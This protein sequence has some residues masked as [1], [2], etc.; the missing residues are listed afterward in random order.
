[1]KINSDV[2][3]DF[4]KTNSLI[5]SIIVLVSVS[6]VLPSGIQAGGPVPSPC[7]RTAT[8][9][10]VESTVHDSYT[11]YLKKATKRLKKQFGNNRLETFK[12]AW[13]KV[14]ESINFTVNPE[15]IERHE[16]DSDSSSGEACRAQLS[17]SIRD[18]TV[19]FPIEYTIKD[20]QVRLSKNLFQ[21][22]D[23][24]F[25]GLSNLDLSPDTTSG[26]SSESETGSMN[27]S[28]TDAITFSNFR[29][30]S[31][32]PHRIRFKVD[33]SINKNRVKEEN[34][35]LNVTALSGGERLWDGFDSEGT[36]LRSNQG[37]AELTLT[38]HTLNP[39]WDG[40]EPPRKTSTD[41][42]QLRAYLSDNHKVKK[43]Y[44][45]KKNWVLNQLHKPSDTIPD[46]PS[47]NEIT[48]NSVSQVD[49]TSYRVNYDYVYRSDHGPAVHLGVHA[50]SDDGIHSSCCTFITEIKRGKHS[51][52]TKFS[53]RVSNIEDH[54][55]T[56]KLRLSFQIGMMGDDFFSKTIDHRINWAKGLKTVDKTTTKVLDN[57]TLRKL[58]R[59]ISSHD[60]LEDVPENYVD[61]Y[62]EKA[63]ETNNHAAYDKLLRVY[64][65]RNRYE[66]ATKRPLYNQ[67]LR[68]LL[69]AKESLPIGQ[70]AVWFRTTFAKLFEKNNHLQ[71]IFDGA[72][73]E[74]TFNRMRKLTQSPMIETS[75]NQLN[76]PNIFTHHPDHPTVQI[77][78]QP[79]Q[80]YGSGINVFI[81]LPTSHYVETIRVNR[82][83]PDYLS[84]SKYKDLFLKRFGNFNQSHYRTYTE[85]GNRSIKY[86]YNT[87]HTED[88]W[89]PLQQTDLEWISLTLP[90]LGVPRA[91]YRLDL[92]SFQIPVDTVQ[93][94]DTGAIEREFDHY[95]ASLLEWAEQ[96][97]KSY[98]SDS[99]TKVSPPGPN[100]DT[101]SM[102]YRL[103]TGA[104]Y[105]HK[106]SVSKAKQWLASIDSIQSPY[107]RKWAQMYGLLPLDYLT[108]DEFLEYRDGDV[109]DRIRRLTLHDS[110][111]LA[112]YELA[113]NYWQNQQYDKARRLFQSVV[114]SIKAGAVLWD[115]S[116][117]YTVS[118]FYRQDL[119]KEAIE[120]LE[121]YL[122][123]T[124]QLRSS[125]HKP[126]FFEVEGTF[127]NGLPMRNYLIHW[128][129]AM[130][131]GKK[132]WWYETVGEAEE[133][134]RYY[135]YFATTFQRE[136][137]GRL[138]TNAYLQNIGTQRAYM[139]HKGL[140]G[141][142][143]AGTITRNEL[144][145][146]LP[147]NNRMHSFLMEPPEKLSRSAIQ[148]ALE[149]IPTPPN[150]VRG[151]GPG[152][153]YYSGELNVENY[154]ERVL[155][156]GDPPEGVAVLSMPE[157]LTRMIDRMTRHD[158]SSWSF[159]VE[160][161][162]GRDMVEEYLRSASPV[163]S[164]IGNPGRSDIDPQPVNPEVDSSDASRTRD[165]A[166]N[167]F[168]EFLGLN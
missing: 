67:A 2:Q 112:R 110:S 61:N 111:V 160:P 47:V 13:K 88:F 154:L 44:P 122:Y 107:A 138:V 69:H 123:R 148:E 10:A 136:P 85:S 125:G 141:G 73:D 98:V 23:E 83:I 149:S 34:P 140:R 27:R 105:L 75:L 63:G 5:L 70:H 116:R 39:Q 21:L 134:I 3:S 89:I 60:S 93:P 99:Y 145:M 157:F 158:L 92:T 80:Q 50:L 147:W 115:E 45:F 54:P 16:T 53:R 8:I 126:F 162:T 15:T 18:Y 9:D 152:A 143:P 106:G 96:V 46:D 49:S 68:V 156:Q 128:L 151:R 168:W 133:P 144:F 84:M 37:T 19:D 104:F 139:N 12:K 32:K 24:G 97:E 150:P 120:Q 36:F 113:R 124:T 43:R 4:S 119:R 7:H 66:V 52:S 86:A 159:R 142:F 56:D 163:E 94:L 1:V 65:E 35:Y 28:G 72:F 57:S 135:R 132:S 58:L 87:F 155:N 109:N 20:G 103:L 51:G 127:T 108:W 121:T 55:V 22:P 78:D 102:E 82:L 71:P 14:Q 30:I 59:K 100:S 164:P 11:S 41:Q 74:Q 42:L 167:G 161:L 17:L 117:L 165:E 91:S 38:Y 95:S 77:P 64:L 31:Q 90:Q 130:R 79:I 40:K 114:N 29:M 26:D 25:S 153:N 6:M 129:K 118:S 62:L 48:V 33:Y 166:S 76:V 137:V 81:H 101:P 131:K 146:V